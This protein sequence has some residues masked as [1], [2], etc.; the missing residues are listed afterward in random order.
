VP[1]YLSG[2]G[3]WPV[4]CYLVRRG[5]KGDIFIIPLIVESNVRGKVHFFLAPF[6]SPVH[7]GG[8]VR[9]GRILVQLATLHWFWRWEGM[10]IGAH[11]CIQYRNPGQRMLLSICLHTSS[12]NF[13]SLELEICSV[14]KST[15][16]SYRGPGLNSQYQHGTS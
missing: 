6:G 7:Q 12:E 11:L 9:G 1:C 14:E 3:W 10:S 4:S 15:R 8:R 16:L 2:H 13:H 5:W